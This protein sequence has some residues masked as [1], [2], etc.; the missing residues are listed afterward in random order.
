MSQFVQ[1]LF[2]AVA[3]VSGLAVVAAVT[4]QSSDADGF[5]AALGGADSSRFK[6]G[7]KEELLDR[8]AK[9]GAGVWIV[10]CII[11]A[12]MWYHFGA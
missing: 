2:G 5:S 8:V 9:Y 7:S 6:K 11:T 12:A 1:Y 3:L 10:S 4:M